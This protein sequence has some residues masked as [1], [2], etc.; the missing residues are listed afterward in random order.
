M[1][2]YTVTTAVFSLLQN[3]VAVGA[4]SEKYTIKVIPIVPSYLDGSPVISP[5]SS[6]TINLASAISPLSGNNN[7][8]PLSGNNSKPLSGI[9]G[10]KDGSYT[11]K[12]DTA[13]NQVTLYDGTYYIC[14]DCGNGQIDNKSYNSTNNSTNEWEP[15]SFT[16]ITVKG[17][18]TE[19]KGKD[20][21]VSGN[22]SDENFLIGMHASENGK[23]VLEAPTVKGTTI[24]LRATNGV[25]EVKNG[26]IEENH[27]GVDAAE[28]SFVLLE[29][30]DIKTANGNASLLSYDRSEIWMSGGSIDF[31]NSHGIS[32]RLGGKINL[33]NV[34]I[35]GKGKEKNSGNHAVVHTDLEGDVNLKGT[36]ISATDIHGILLENAV[37]IS[38][39]IPFQKVKDLSDEDSESKVSVTEV[40]I[41]SSSVNVNGHGSYGIYFKG[42]K[43]LTE[44]NLHEE[45][46]SEEDKKRS[47]MEFVDL[48]KTKFSVEDNAI[49]STNIIKGIVSLTESTLSS[50]N[51]FLK[52]EK[53]A[54]LTVL[55]THSTLE[56]GAHIDDISTAKLY[57]GDN[58]EWILRKSGEREQSGLSLINDSSVSHVTLMNESSIKFTKLKP[59]ADQSYSYQKL[60]IGNG[61]GVA[62]KAQDG[63]H[64]YFNTYLNEGG[65]LDKQQTDRVLIHGDVEGKTMVHV[66]AV[67]GSPG[68]VTGSGGN[69]QGIS[70]IQVSGKAEKDS[71]Q[72]D[73]GYVALDNAPYQYRLYA[74][75]PSSELGQ[76]EASQRQVKGEGDFWDFRLENGYVKPE[77]EPEPKPAPDPLP[78]PTPSPEPEPLP[79][80]GVKAVVPQ[81]PTYLLLPNALFHTDL[82]NID[83]KNKWLESLRVVSGG[84]LEM[85]ETPAFFMRGYG[86]N[87]RYTSNL[88]MLEYG[89]GGELDYNAIDAGVLLQ[90]IENIYGSSSFGVIG[91]Y[92]RLSLQPLNVEQSRK[93]TFDKWVVTAYGGM[94]WDAGFYVDGLLSYGLF[95]GDVLTLARDKT[96]T[97]KGNSLSASLTS[98]K[99]FMIG[100]EGLILDP[101][102]QV[103]YQRLQ[104][105][106]AHDIDDFDIEI[107]NIDQWVTRVGGRLT[108]MLTVGEEARVI[109][110]YGKV[111]VA[112]GFGGKQFAH[113]KDAFQL[114]AFGSALETGLGFNAQLSPKFV[115]HG[116]LVYQHKLTK[117]GFSGTSFS[118]GLRYN[119]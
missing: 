68:G 100:D 95:K 14:N 16:A 105:N 26:K 48:N 50:K 8:K 38:N 19:V 72:L 60:S 77:P 17:I 79:K 91:S 10:D 3:G 2:L 32:S 11:Y 81:V 96:A 25:I 64:I 70:I 88:S 7:S 15:T 6:G 39:S 82:I 110:F 84:M 23:I 106:K 97:L 46:S 35:T 90:K 67:S 20:V 18:G 33:E 108:K 47:R 113:F 74:Y 55:A 86:G 45:D 89:Y 103:V 92:E 116:D 102:I 5:G 52:A 54:S 63:A 1:C 59:A 65:P 119:F 49:Q 30:T 109:S 56:G 117:A 76:G 66:R 12:Y 44:S 114:G 85:R 69:N 107:G 111:H 4:N 51:L 9:G 28:S 62:Y 43:P 27:E 31:M 83:N 99:P 87:H 22:V 29:D 75:G 21:T 13:K 93:S 61:I 115:L 58:S 104:F 24:A 41:K 37:N 42:N 112:H 40:N 53:G 34:K 94:Q 57:L 36:T 98:G 78:G 73:G 80:P 71:F 101:Q 118:G